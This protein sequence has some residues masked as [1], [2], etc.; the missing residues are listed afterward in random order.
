MKVEDFPAGQRVTWIDHNR[1]K[2]LAGVV[3][4]SEVMHHVVRVTSRAT[5]SG[6]VRT[7]VCMAD[8]D[9]PPMAGRFHLELA[10]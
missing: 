8:E 7:F 10:P 2:P 9:R 6:A 3:V 5:E 4:E 1:D